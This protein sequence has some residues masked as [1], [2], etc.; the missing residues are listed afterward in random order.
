MQGEKGRESGPEPQGAP[1]FSS[2][3][4]G[5]CQQGKCK[6]EEGNQRVSR[7]SHEG[8]GSQACTQGAP[9]GEKWME[10][11]SVEVTGELS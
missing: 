11:S 5:R 7:G 4:G 8:S 6:R 10:G 2:R 3:R 1:A 9:G